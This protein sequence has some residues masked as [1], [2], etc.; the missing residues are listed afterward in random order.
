VNRRK[1]FDNRE[2]ES[3]LQLQMRQNVENDPE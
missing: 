2:T 1:P 3:G